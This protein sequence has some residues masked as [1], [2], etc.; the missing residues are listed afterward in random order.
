MRDC[1]GFL[2]KPNSSV[3]GAV[4]LF[5]IAFV[6]DLHCRILTSTAFT[7]DLI[8]PFH[9]TIFIYLYIFP[10]LFFSYCFSNASFPAPQIGQTQSSGR[11]SNDVPAAIPVSGSPFAGS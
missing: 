8:P 9:I 5:T 2:F 7:H 4:F 6:L 1:C 3:A 11:S 10:V